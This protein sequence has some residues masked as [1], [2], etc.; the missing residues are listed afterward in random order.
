MAFLVVKDL[1]SK[2]FFGTRFIT[3]SVFGIYFGCSAI[4]LS[5]TSIDDAKEILSIDEEGVLL[6][7]L[8]RD[9]VNQSI[10]HLVISIISLFC[11]FL[12]RSRDKEKCGVS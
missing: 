12:L 6:H 2:K 3:L 7:G 8:I 9:E 11:Y 4:Y 10:L 1:V 5:M